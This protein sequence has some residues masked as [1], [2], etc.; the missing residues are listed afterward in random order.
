MGF[1]KI[2]TRYRVSRDHISFKHNN[3]T[4]GRYSLL[5]ALCSD[6]IL[7]ADI[8]RGAY[9]GPAF[10]QYIRDLMPYMKPYPEPCSVLVMDNCPIHHLDDVAHICEEQ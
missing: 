3:Q 8:R 7:Y 9:D 4:V 5:P 1:F 6:G 2:P 10:V